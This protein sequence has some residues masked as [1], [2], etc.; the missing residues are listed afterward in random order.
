VEI[1]KTATSVAFY[2]IASPLGSL[3]R[4]RSNPFSRSILSGTYKI[5]K[6]KSHFFYQNSF[7]NSKSSTQ[8]KLV[9]SAIVILLAIRLSVALVSCLLIL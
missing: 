2:L 3:S 7:I 8:R 1:A 6:G 4:R 9:I 5:H